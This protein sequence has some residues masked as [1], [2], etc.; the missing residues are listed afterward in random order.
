MHV[1]FDKP[2]PR[3]DAAALQ[4]LADPRSVIIRTIARAHWKVVE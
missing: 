2:H 3:R 4:D 1:T